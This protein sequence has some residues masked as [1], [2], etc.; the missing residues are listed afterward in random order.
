MTRFKPGDIARVVDMS[1]L[2]LP[3]GKPPFAEGETVEIRKVTPEG[4][5]VTVTRT[6][7]GA[8]QHGGWFA[9]RRFEKL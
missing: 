2:K 1:G 8:D 4:Q 5:S 7:P 9:A 3:K 6:L